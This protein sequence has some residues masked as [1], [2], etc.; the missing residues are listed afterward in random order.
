[1]NIRERAH[2]LIDRMP[3][4]QVPALVALLETIVEPVAAAPRTLRPPRLF[5]GGTI[6]RWELVLL[7]G[8]DRNRHSGLRFAG[9][10]ALLNR[11][12]AVAFLQRGK[13]NWCDEFLFP[14]VIELDDYVFFV[15]V[16]DCAEAKPQM[17]H[18]STW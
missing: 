18:L 9:A 15:T 12:C 17:L 11:R 2:Q 5:P 6:G 14:M 8:G 13:D 1:M 16:H 10:R 3:D 4:I 7:H